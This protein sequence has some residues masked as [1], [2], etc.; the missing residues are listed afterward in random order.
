MSLARSIM[1]RR[2]NT[3]A[4]RARFSGFST[5][6]DFRIDGLGAPAIHP[7]KVARS[8]AP[9]AA[10]KFDFSS[11]SIASG[12]QSRFYFIKTNA[13]AFDVKGITAIVMRASATA[14]SQGVATLQTAEPIGATARTGAITGI[15]F[16]DLNGDG[17][18]Q[19][20]D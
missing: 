13:V 10:L 11:V 7:T 6:V 14:N 18:R 1:F 16:N 4:I 8:G 5:D 9:G 12:Q 17:K 19:S 2:S 3:R 20:T 15:K